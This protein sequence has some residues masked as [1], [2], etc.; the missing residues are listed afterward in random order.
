MQKIR[1]LLHRT[2]FGLSAENISLSRSGRFVALPTSK[3]K[4]N[5]EEC[6]LCVLWSSAI[7]SVLIRRQLKTFQVLATVA[8]S[9][10]LV[11]SQLRL[12]SEGAEQRHGDERTRQSVT[13]TQSFNCTFRNKT[14]CW[15]KIE[16]CFIPPCT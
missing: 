13:A 8:V 16:I 12:C 2:T 15:L 14:K 1:P 11:I 6:D 7:L 3:H 4:Y 9:L 10:R 5:R